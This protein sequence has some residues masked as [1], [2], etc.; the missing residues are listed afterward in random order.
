MHI[1]VE[2]ALIVYP[3]VPLNVSRCA[4]EHHSGVPRRPYQCIY[5]YKSLAASDCAYRQ[6]HNETLK[7]PGGKSKNAPLTHS[8]TLAHTRGLFRSMHTKG[9]YYSVKRDL[10]C[11][12]ARSLSKHAHTHTHAVSF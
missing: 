7:N 3:G 2:C 5:Q 8:C 1:G 9:T 6:K 10:L 4:Y 11:I 12:H